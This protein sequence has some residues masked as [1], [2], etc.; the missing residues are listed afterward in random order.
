MHFLAVTL[1]PPIL[2]L[3]RPL[4][5]KHFDQGTHLTWWVHQG[6]VLNLLFIS[7]PPSFLHTM[8]KQT[9]A[10]W[11]GDKVKGKA[12]KNRQRVIKTKVVYLVT[13]YWGIQGKC[14]KNSQSGFGMAFTGCTESTRV[15]RNGIWL[16]KGWPKQVP[17]TS[18]HPRWS[19]TSPR[20]STMS[21]KMWC[22]TATPCSSCACTCNSAN[23]K[24]TIFCTCYN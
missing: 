11:S 13:N 16:G 6:I 12:V 19:R 2:E 18:H 24:C 1:L 22:H 23:M 5:S 9:V 21:N 8:D 7:L 20:D 4:Y 10:E 15:G 14:L 3:E 17:S